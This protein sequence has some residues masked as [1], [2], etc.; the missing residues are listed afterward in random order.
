MGYPVGYL[1]IIKLLNSSK[2]LSYKIADLCEEL[3]IKKEDVLFA[4]KEFNKL[5]NLVEKKEET[6]ILK[7]KLDLLDEDLIFKQIVGAGRV[8]VLES[9]D[10]TNTYTLKNTTNVISG[11]TVFAEIQTA[12]RGRR[13]GKLI[14][15]FARQLTF[16]TSYIF[17]NVVKIQG[18]SIG[19]GV[20]VA[21]AIESFG[22]N[23]I[24]IKWPNDIYI[25]DC[26]VGGILI[27]VAT[28]GSKVKAVIG[29]GLNVYT[30]NLAVTDRRY[31]SLAEGPSDTFNRNLLATAL[32][33]SIKDVCFSFLNNDRDKIL[34]EFNQRDYLKGK[35]ISIQTEQGIVQGV[36][37]GIDSTG[38]ILLNTG[39]SIC[40]VNVGHIL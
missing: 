33:N 26:K 11:D 25:N 40:S 1:A 19:I 36:A 10:S 37:Y 35:Q 28:D 22:I 32:I 3:T 13:G 21:N 4:I 24:K 15:G 23:G 20:A 7:R 34:T 5:F 12:G 18:L 16:S 9:V 29:V 14:S 39:E 30:D 17:D 38:A 6:L 27:E 31:C 2:N 8:L